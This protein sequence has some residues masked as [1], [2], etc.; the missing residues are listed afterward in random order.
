MLTSALT[1]TGAPTSAADT[2]GTLVLLALA[3]FLALAK[4]GGDLAARVKQPSVLG[5]LVAGVLLGN[6]ALLGIDWAE[7]FKT[8]ATL[9]TLA[10]L[11]VI[12]LLFEVG[13]ESTVRDM[14][15]VGWTSLLVAV[16]GVVTPF[17]LGWGVG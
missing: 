8:D 12:I 3:V 9:E 7:P 14:L 4:V 10:Q 15:K 16:L 11:G 6:L 13:L 5:E 2:P 17:A 1:A